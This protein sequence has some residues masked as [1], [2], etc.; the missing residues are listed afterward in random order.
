[1]D[2]FNVSTTVQCKPIYVNTD[3]NPVG[4]DVSGQFDATRADAGVASQNE[5]T[6]K[7][8]KF[9]EPV[10]N[11]DMD[12]V[13]TGTLHNEGESPANWNSRISS[14]MAPLEDPSYSYSPNLLP[15]LE[16]HSSFVSEGTIRPILN[17]DFF[18]VA[19]HDFLIKWMISYR[20]R[21]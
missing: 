19:V 7:Q 8:V 4:H 9:H 2:I 11:S 5:E 17:F 15:V 14:Y 6:T 10:N 21:R 1:M 12:D 16:E 18:G 3:R 20:S 13:D